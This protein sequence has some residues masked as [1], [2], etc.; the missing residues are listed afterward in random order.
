MQKTS[1]TRTSDGDEAVGVARDDVVAAGRLRVGGVGVLRQRAD[2]GP[3]A[4]HVTAAHLDSEVLRDG[5]QD[6]LH[7][8]LVRLRPHRDFALAVCP[9]QDISSIRERAELA[10]LLCK[11][12]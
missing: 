7:L 3:G 6:E 5:A 11:R 2:A 10:K 12:M 9:A 1:M 8:I 4:Q